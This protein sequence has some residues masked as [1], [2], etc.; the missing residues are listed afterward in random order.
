MSDHVY[1]YFYQFDEFENYLKSKKF[2]G[3]G[4]EAIA[5]P[6]RPFDSSQSVS[7]ILSWNRNAGLHLLLKSPKSEVSITRKTLI[8]DEWE[9]KEDL[10]RFLPDQNS[11]IIFQALDRQ[12][13][14][15]VWKFQTGI[16]FSGIL[17]AKKGSFHFLNF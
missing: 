5:N 7:V 8:E 15:L 1:N 13:I 11:E 16:A 17:E 10:F 2:I 14:H 4:I 6:E 9:R 12:R 3:K